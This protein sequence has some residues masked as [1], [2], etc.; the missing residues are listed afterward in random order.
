MY[1]I[2]AKRWTLQILRKNCFLFIVLTTTV[3]VTAQE[4]WSV[5]FRPQLNFPVSSFMN[6]DLRVGNGL[7]LETTYNIMPHVALY[8]GVHWSQVDTNERFNEE[9]ID[10]NQGGYIF[11]ARL[12]LPFNKSNIG[13]YVSA[14]TI[15]SRIRIT[16]DTSSN[17]Q[18]TDFTF[19]WQ[20]GSGILIPV[21]EHWTFTTELRYRFA[22]ST[23]VL[24]DATEQ[25]LDLEFI[26]I[27][28]GATYRF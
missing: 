8:G 21:F 25:V 28:A 7:E 17:N 26:T 16:S 24:I 15:Y 9:H 27:S 20:L 13:Y 5:T 12:R 6:K 3:C 4:R 10:F 11:G 19:N 22:P 2:K 1:A 14:G 23:T 18:K